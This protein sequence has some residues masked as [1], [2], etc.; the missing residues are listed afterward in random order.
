MKT[1]AKLTTVEYDSIVRNNDNPELTDISSYQQLVEKLI[2]LTITR[3]Y[4]CFAV[5]V[6]SQ[7]MQHS[8][9]SHWDVVLRVLTY[10][11][12]TL[13]QGVL[14]MKGPITSLT[15]YCDLDW[16]TCPSTRRP[17]TGYVI[18]LGDSLISWKSKKQQ[19]IS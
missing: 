4:I 17:V 1:N 10:L 11:K 18:Q 2:Y 8:K 12:K 16:A 19:T 5:Q 3:P 15:T 7:F 9:R 14:L 13:G 6:L